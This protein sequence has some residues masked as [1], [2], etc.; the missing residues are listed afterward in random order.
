[1]ATW[2]P[3]PRDEAAV[4]SVANALKLA[5]EWLIVTHERPDG[6]AIGSA[7]AM[8]HI[9][10]HLG[11]RWVFLVD[12]ALPTRFEYLPFAQQTTC[13]NEQYNQKFKYVIAVDCADEARFASVQSAMAPDAKIINI[14]HHWTNPRYGIEHCVDVEAA[15][16]CELLYHVARVLE[17]PIQNGLASSLYT[18]IL[19][20]TGG[21]ALPNTTREVHQIAA[22]LLESGV[23]PYDIAEPALESKSSEQMHLLQM[24]LTNLTISS[25][26]KYAAIYVTRGMLEGAGATED[27]VEGL[28][29]FARCIDTV[30]VGMLFKETPDNRVKV[31]L[32][33]KRYVDVS[34]IAQ[35]YGGGGHTRASG[36]VIALPLGDAMD[37]M[38][39]TVEEALL[40]GDSE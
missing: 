29:G 17:V 11:K 9:L 28:V 10:T 12:E 5:D 6:D 39:L 7:L 24:A 32:R 15:A 26:G 1:M 30:E 25:D 23:R 8:A 3:A 22:E 16:T 20:D 27:D 37:A 2:V 31:S 4:V 35:L 13:M 38:V 14:D 21:F 36:C 34:K 40:E 33:S 19:T 18:G